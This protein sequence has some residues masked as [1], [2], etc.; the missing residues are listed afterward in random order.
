[1][2]IRI[3]V[4]AHSHFKVTTN[5]HL[6]IATTDM[7]KCPLSSNQ[8]IIQISLMSAKQRMQPLAI[9][10]AVI[11]PYCIRLPLIGFW[12]A[13]Q[14]RITAIRQLRRQLPTNAF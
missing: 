9:N 14:L 1:M 8:T 2:T 7:M 11:V 4:A 10:E 3:K 6:K 5:W 13:A 12:E